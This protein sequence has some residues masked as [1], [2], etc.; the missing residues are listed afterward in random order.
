M[1]TRNLGFV[2]LF[3][4]VLAVTACNAKTETADDEKR[5]SE[6]HVVTQQGTGGH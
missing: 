3:V 6:G 2:A 1:C 5:L 4:A